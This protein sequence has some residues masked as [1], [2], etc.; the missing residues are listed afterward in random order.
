MDYAHWD[1]M[2]TRWRD[3]DVYGHLN[4]VVHYEL[5][6][7]VIN[8]WL[9]SEAG[10][11]PMTGPSI[12]LCV[13]SRCTYTAEAAYPAVIRVGLRVGRLG[14]SSVRYELGLF[15][16]GRALAEGEFTHVFVDRRTRRPAPIE[17]RMRAAME[18]LVVA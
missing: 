4:N 12:G 10:L 18:R 16:G 2:P 11:D 15:E 5:M 1:E 8:R 17:G 3:N 6:D 14:T 9:I 7:S 13:E